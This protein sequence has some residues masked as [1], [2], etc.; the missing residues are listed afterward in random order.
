MF[1]AAAAEEEVSEQVG[2]VQ[3]ESDQGG[4][5]CR[6]NGGGEYG[7]HVAVAELIACPEHGQ[8]LIAGTRLIQSHRKPR[9]IE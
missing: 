7:V 4:C 6:R 2:A 8:E 1:L 3:A 9:R 5:G